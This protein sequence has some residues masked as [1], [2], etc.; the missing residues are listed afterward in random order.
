MENSLKGMIPVP[1][2]ILTQIT[3]EEIKHLSFTITPVLFNIGINEHATLAGKFGNNGP[4][5]H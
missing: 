1:N 2:Y 4:Q 5:V 3:I